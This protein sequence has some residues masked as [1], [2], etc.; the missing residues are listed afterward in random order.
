MRPAAINAAARKFQKSHNC[1]GALCPSSLFDKIFAEVDILLRLY[2]EIP[3]FLIRCK[4]LRAL[5]FG[6]PAAFMP[7]AL[8]LANGRQ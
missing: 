4:T 5:V 8:Q 6:S 3:S 1:L 2:L 7:I